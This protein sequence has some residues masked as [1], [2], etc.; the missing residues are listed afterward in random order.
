MHR[1]AENKLMMKNNLI[2]IS[3]TE[4]PVKPITILPKMGYI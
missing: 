3:I 1:L 4:N 2:V